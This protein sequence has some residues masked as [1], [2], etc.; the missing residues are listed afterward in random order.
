VDNDQDVLELHAFVKGDV[1]GVGFRAKT[2]SLAVKLGL[3][4]NVRNLADGSVEIYAQGSPEKLKEL[5]KSLNSFFKDSIS[6]V[7]ENYH[8]VRVSCTNFDIISD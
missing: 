7:N 8:P 3:H 6:S 5:V 2:R 1:Q 4:G